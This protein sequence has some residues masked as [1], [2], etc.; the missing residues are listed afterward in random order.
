M[1]ER[2]V[3]KQL[4]VADFIHEKERELQSGVIN[5]P[6]VKK[7]IG[8]VSDVNLKI[9]KTKIQGTYIQLYPHTAPEI[10]GVLEDVCRILGHTPVPELYL[11]KMMSKIIQPCTAEV[12][13]IIISDYV[14]EQ[15]DRDMLY[16]AFGNAVTMILAGHVKMTTAAA[17][18]GCNIWTVLPQVKFK[19]YL[20]AADATSDRGGLLACQSLAAS[21]RCHL[22]ELGIPP[23][24][25]RRYFT[26]DA[27]AAAFIEKYLDA[28]AENNGTNRSFSA[29]GEWWINMV[30]FEG[31]GNAMLEDLYQWYRRDYDRL[32]RKY[33]QEVV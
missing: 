1:A 16:F 31:A 23:V 29:L 12:D 10:F 9:N 6:E 21:A 14:L 2:K 17:Y 30:S 24:C 33:T 4:Q 19:E 13:Y 20:H 28:V 3:L 25:S 7:L 15:Y 26:T 27:E 22:L 8:M 18:M 11:C 32:L 5:S